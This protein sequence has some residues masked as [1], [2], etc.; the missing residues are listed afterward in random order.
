MNLLL[1]DSHTDFLTSIPNSADR[2]K[3]IASIANC[4]S[5]I[6]CAVFTTEHHFSLQELREYIDEI[7]YLSKK[8]NIS[9]IF[10]VEDLGFV[11]NKTDL[12]NLVKLKPFSATL[13]WNYENQYAGGSNSHS[14][15]TKLG[16]E[17]IN[18]LEDNNILVDTAHLSK[19]SFDEFVKISRLPLF[20]SHSNIENLYHHKRNLDYDQIK[21]IV[22]SNGYLGLTIYNKFISDSTINYWDVAYQFDWLIKN[23]GA[24]NF[25]FGTDLYGFDNSYLPT[26]VKNFNDLIKV[27]SALL[28]MGHCLKNVEKIMY[29]N[30]SNFVK[31]VSTLNTVNYN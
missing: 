10:S 14:G 25:G 29:D 1:S 9:L 24:N 2:E 31:N 21:K 28:K 3:Y 13:T 6:C 5:T 26:N 30:F 4:S 8:Y 22:D 18:F 11:K 27:S 16:I 20:N 23:F 17:T 15:L 12:I 19:Q 7:T